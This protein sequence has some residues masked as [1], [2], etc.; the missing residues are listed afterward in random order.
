MYCVNCGNRIDSNDK[1]CTRCGNMLNIDNSKNR[2][3]VDRNGYSGNK[4]A[5]IILGTLSIGFSMFIIFAPIGLVFSIIG[6]ILC[7]VIIKN[8]KNVIGIV[9]NL[10]GFLISLCICIL[11]MF[12][13]RYV[14]A[15]VDSSF[16]DDFKYSEKNNELDF[17]DYGEK[18]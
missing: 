14:V 11:F 6:L 4:I 10:I 18:F 8:E 15:N 5:S 7:F 16:I 17:G 13:I 9:L 3:C 1:Y 12:V 2:D